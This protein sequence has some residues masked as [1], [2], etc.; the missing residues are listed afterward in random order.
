LSK[1][2]NSVGSRL[3]EFA[4][5]MFVSYSD[6]A[7]RLETRPQ[8]LNNFFS[9]QTMPGAELL[10]RL[11]KLGLNINWLMTGMGEMLFEDNKNTRLRAKML[12]LVTSVQC[13]VPSAQWISNTD[14][15]IEFDGLKGLLNPF[16]VIAQGMSM[17]Q[18]ILPGD[19]L[20]CYESDE[21]I[22]D[23]DIVLVNFQSEPDTSQGIVKRVKFLDDGKIILYSDNA[24]NFPPVLY[25][26]SDIYKFYPVHP[27]CLRGLK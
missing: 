2:K 1:I 12:P 14:R 6:L 24:R 4:D 27:K 3:R 16:A 13:G 11:S 19:I 17:A 5:K 10:A 21:D 15:H 18:T 23:G 25:R 9:G 8:H 7:N 22:K 26:Q 20:V